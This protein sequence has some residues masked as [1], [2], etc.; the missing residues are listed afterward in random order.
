MATISHSSLGKLQGVSKGDVTQFWGIKY[1][2]LG[3]RFGT[4]EIY[5]GQASDTVDAT[6][7]G[8]ATIGIP[9]ACQ[10]EY[11]L[12]Q[13]SLPTPQLPPPSDTECLNLNITIP[14]SA[15]A[16]TGLPIV[17]F[18]HGGALA[19]GSANWPQYDFA[20]LV[21]RSIK[22]GKPFIGVS[23]NYRTGIF[24]FLTSEE[25]RAAGFKANNGLRDQKV[26][27]QWIKKNIAGFGGNPDEVSVL[28]QSA[29]GGKIPNLQPPSIVL[30][31]IVNLAVSATLQLQSNEPLFKR[32]VNLSGTCL[33]LRPLPTFVHEMFYSG[34]CEAHGLDKLSGEERVKAIEKISSLDLFLKVPPFIPSL[35][36]LDR[37]FITAAPTF[38]SAED[39]SN[40]SK[41]ELAGL[42]WCKEIIIGDSQMD[43]NIYQLALGHR[44]PGIGKEFGES[45]KRNITGN[46]KEVDQLLAEYGIS[47]AKDDQSA[48]FA[49]L[50]LGNDICFY[51]PEETFARN[52]PGPT[53]VY[54]LNEPNPWDGPFKGQCT[55]IFDVALLFKNFDQHLDSSAKAVG[56]KLGDSIIEFVSGQAPWQATTKDKPVAWVLGGAAGI[57]RLMEDKPEK[58]G[59]RTAMFDYKD[60]I[61]WD[62]LHEAYTAFL[63]GR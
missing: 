9:D 30:A 21:Q 40:S 7:V 10:A 28:G 5:A 55:H 36:V 33:L 1:A 56:E 46:H 17:V 50:E 29:G 6:K 15:S 63:G 61:G 11:G 51:L 44:I 20:P 24:G 2:S 16:R 32:M 22:L 43:G 54:H 60:T 49:I 26:A 13:R 47:S 14:A 4:P 48:Y 53:Y 31:N 25:L 23:I 35:P 12:I 37:D 39:W 27:L 42:E 3:H 59:R 52:W 19:M 8:P 34:V 18:I 58:V 38:A 62:T 45:L 57:G 41:P